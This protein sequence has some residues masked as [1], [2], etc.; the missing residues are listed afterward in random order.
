MIRD[1]ATLKAAKQLYARDRLRAGLPPLKTED[2]EARPG[3]TGPTVYRLPQGSLWTLWVP[4]RGGDRVPAP[5]LP[6]R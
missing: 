3:A 4:G 5:Q 1:V 6:P 2:A